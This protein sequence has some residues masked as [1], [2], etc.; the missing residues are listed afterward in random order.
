MA[1]HSGPVLLLHMLHKTN[2]L[3]KRNQKWYM[4]L[5]IHCPCPTT[6]KIV[7]S[8]LGLYASLMTR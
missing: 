4:A 5:F 8:E 7:H 2:K 1:E 3:Y 6:H